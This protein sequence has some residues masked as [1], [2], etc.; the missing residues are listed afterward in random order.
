MDFGRPNAGKNLVKA[1]AKVSAFISLRGMAS[2][3]LVDAHIMVNRY[4]LPDLVLGRGLTQSIIILLDD[5]SK[6]GI[7]LS[8]A[9]GIA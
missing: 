8:G 6:A 4:W 7:G 3:N 2:G 9:F 1:L 5:S